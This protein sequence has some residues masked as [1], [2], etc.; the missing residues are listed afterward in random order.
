VTPQRAVEKGVNYIVMGRPI[1]DT[2]NIIQA[3]RRFFDETK[4]VRF[5]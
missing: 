2:P 3:V 4:A 5:Q 1:L